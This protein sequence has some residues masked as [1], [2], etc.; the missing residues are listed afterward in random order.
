MGDIL[1]CTVRCVHGKLWQIGD[2]VDRAKLELFGP[3]PEA[4]FGVTRGAEDVSDERE[5]TDV[6]RNIL[7]A[8]GVKFNP[9]LGL[10][11][12]EALLHQVQDTEKDPLG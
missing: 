8:K 3:T 1:V 4:H 5:K 11:K 10:V 9:R 6:I 12:L 2:V 7:K